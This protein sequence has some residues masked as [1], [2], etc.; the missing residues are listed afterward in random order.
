M[1]T[2][3]LNKVFRSLTV[4]QLK[5]II[6]NKLPVSLDLDIDYENSPGFIDP[7]IY[8]QNQIT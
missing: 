6:D 8:F 7:K 3:L 1:L 5:M 4:R 2:E